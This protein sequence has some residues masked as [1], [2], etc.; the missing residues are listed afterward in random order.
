MNDD[1]KILISTA[2][3]IQKSQ[4]DVESKLHQ[5]KIDP[6]VI[7][8]KIDDKTLMQSIKKVEKLKIDK[9]GLELDKSK[10]TN[11]LETY[12]KNN[13]RAAKTLG[14]EFE[15]IKK[16]IKDADRQQF[17][18]LKKQF[19][20][21]T[22]T[23]K[24]MGLEVETIGQKLE[25]N[26]KQFANYML[27]ATILMQ[28][29]RSVQGMVDN[30]TKLDEAM[31]SLRKVT[32]ETDA[33][34]KRFF[35]NAASSAKKYGA[36]LV[37]VINSSADFARLGYNMQDSLKLAEV[38]SIYSNVGEISIGEGSQ[39]IVSTMKAFGYQ[40]EDAIEIIDKFNEV[41]NNFSISSAGI[42][43]SLKR[44]ASALAEANNDLNQSIALQ[45]GANNVVQD[46]EAVGTMWKTVAM[47]IRGAKTELEEM[48][49]D[50]D[51]MA[52]STAKLREQVK[53][54][55][56]FD[57]MLNPDT[58]K[59]TYD[60]IVGIGDK[61]KEI[62]D[63][64]QA[65]LLELLAGKRQGNAL[66]AA[67]NNVE[68]IKKSYESALNSNGSA[69]KENNTQLESLAGKTK[70]MKASMEELSTTLL[71]S[72]VL[73][74][75]VDLGKYSAEFLNIGDG[76]IV[77]LGVLIALVPTLIGLFNTFRTMDFFKNISAS[78]SATTILFKDFYSLITKL[79]KAIAVS[80]A[81]TIGLSAAYQTL[82][83]SI[84]TTSKAILTFLTTNPLGWAILAGTAIFGLVKAYDAWNVTAE[85][86]REIT[87]K[88]SQ[89]YDGLISKLQTL[90]GELK[91]TVDRINELNS[92]ESLTLVEQSELNKLKDTNAEL[93]T[94]I[95]LLKIQKEEK[96]KEKAKSV[97]KEFEKD[98]LENKTEKTYS[99][100]QIKDFGY[101]SIQGQ[102]EEFI[103]TNE[104]D[105]IKNMIVQMEE[106]NKKKENNITLTEEETKK[107][108]D[109][110]KELTDA[111]V[112]FADYAER[113]EIDDD[114]KRSWSEMA[115]L[116][117]KTVDPTQ[118]KADSIKNIFD[119]KQF[120]E[121]KKELISL[122]SQ[123]QITAETL[124][125]PE[126][127]DLV[128]K[129]NDVTGS[130]EQTA[131]EL[132]ALSNSGDMS[133][134]TDSLSPLLDSLK[135]I[136]TH[137]SSIT[138]L[139]NA[140]GEF[141][142]KGIITSQT[143]LKMKEDLKATDDQIVA[144]QK[145]FLSGDENAVKASL[146]QIAS[147][148]ISNIDAIEKLTEQ[149]K[150][151]L[152]L[153]LESIGV[154]NGL[155]VVQDAINQKLEESKLINKIVSTN[156][157]SATTN[158]INA[159][160]DEAKAANV[161]SKSLEILAQKKEAMMKRD[162]IVDSVKA[163]GKGWTSTNTSEYLKYTNIL[164]EEIDTTA[165]TIDRTLN[166]KIDINWDKILDVS[167]AKKT[168]K[169]LSSTF[170]SA[171]NSLLSMF[172]SMIKQG[173]Q[174]KIDGLNKVKDAL[175][176]EAK[177]QKEMQDAQKKALDDELK[178]YKKKID[179]QQEILRLKE[180]EHDYERE[181]KDK[182]SGVI[183]IQS[184]LDKLQFDDS[185]EA[186]KRKLELQDEL[187]KQQADLDEFQHDR[188]IE[189]QED[190]LNKEYSR[191]EEIQNNKLDIIDKQT[192]AYDRQLQKKLA[193][194]DAEMQRIQDY[195]SLESN[196]RAEAIKMMDEKNSVYYQQLLEWNRK[197]G[198]GIDQTVTQNWSNAYKALGQFNGGQINTLSTLNQLTVKMNDFG[199]QTNTSANNADK[200]ANNINKA[201]D[202]QN[203]LNQAKA[204]EPKT[205]TNSTSNT[206]DYIHGGFNI[207]KYANGGVDTQGGLAMLHGTPSKPEMIVNSTDVGKL[208][209]FIKSLPVKTPLSSFT[210]TLNS[211]P[212]TNT[213]TG[214]NF[215]KMFDLTINGNVDKSTLPDISKTVKLAV[216]DVFDTLNKQM[217]GNGI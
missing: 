102:R 152:G 207:P 181:L 108:N 24:T 81:E 158:E 66:A 46:P 60:I 25:K 194:L 43:E 147:S 55:T 120:A 198:D 15:N 142:D 150:I 9:I 141:K 201:V 113:Y 157:V 143:L 35:D 155:I 213:N 133:K 166:K 27:S 40:A 90:E 156:F 125:N 54:M 12:L 107:Y 139:G 174:D 4:N 217:R 47:R 41:G 209:N 87:E 8:A 30:V 92:K 159:L 191:F 205:N 97:K 52:E 192:E 48:G 33:S 39:S 71:E 53:G 127:K 99:T 200:L 18:N 56:G 73:K 163:S 173:Y 7:Q 202:A 190:A 1:L 188:S 58:F 176:E 187:A 168:S 64:D 61:Y 16:R 23:A 203:K 154:K 77:K 109:F 179:A 2:L 171:I 38:A 68:D 22:S 119:D 83:V 21:T 210:P 11:Q 206:W 45:V 128:S 130:A 36:T 172:Q 184:E 196:I 88:L 57:I 106:L 162:Q 161:T 67:L 137:I 165:V 144:L 26:V 20:T 193:D 170:N 132:N 185:A 19:Q 153:E 160:Y 149:E 121:S 111:G 91:T 65:S 178:A 105:Y 135:D 14:N 74:F 93:K 115:S 199:E 104:E 29:I 112:K 110:K 175:E 6:I 145:S 138:S 82:G 96:Q 136:S 212:P 180:Q 197:Y 101:G 116:I 70:Q 72:N 164:K 148:Y 34:Y 17:S 118:Y 122:A 84:G 140:L 186:M 62:S 31:Y 59:S 151:Q 10:F 78:F 79:P 177:L 32:D 76:V 215:E 195:V 167:G 131:I 49:E 129:L 50:T 182:Q 214:F 44:S 28:G 103:T 124:N 98:M 5:L 123:G 51:G 117:N 126:Y 204:N 211:L 3:D 95:N 85:E 75:F 89:E 146:E 94:Q 86:Q 13:T 216:K 114:T 189:L 134:L 208:L 80:K 37:D 63:I 69:I 42:G 169:D 100:G 183:N